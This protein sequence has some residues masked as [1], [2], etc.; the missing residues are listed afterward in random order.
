V[1]V[2]IVSRCICACVCV[3][4]CVCAYLC[5][6]LGLCLCLRAFKCVCRSVSCMR[7]P[8]GVRFHGCRWLGARRRRVELPRAT[9]SRPNHRR[10]FFLE[11]RQ[12]QLAPNTNLRHHY[13]NTII[14]T[15][16][17]AELWLP[18]LEILDQKDK[19][20]ISSWFGRDHVA[21]GGEG[22]RCIYLSVSLPGH[23]R[24]FSTCYCANRVLG[25]A[26]L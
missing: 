13:R 2:C 19:I 5:A 7:M 9:R 22:T 6:R 17:L 10:F 15:R 1:H 23:Q 18:Q 11:L 14:A 20:D 8:V 3:C 24:V 25:K 16:L 26:R 21:R 4:M 12:P